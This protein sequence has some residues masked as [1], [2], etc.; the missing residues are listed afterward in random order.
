MIFD[1]SLIS[2]STQSSAAEP[3]D[4]IEVVG[5]LTHAELALELENSW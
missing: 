3:S 2:P 5:L 4:E 1:P